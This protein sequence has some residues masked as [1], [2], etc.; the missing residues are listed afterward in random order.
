VKGISPEHGKKKAYFGHNNTLDESARFLHGTVYG[1]GSVVVDNRLLAEDRR[2]L[3]L[4][5]LDPI[6]V[7]GTGE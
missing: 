5:K 1:I 3:E 7:S 2:G 4:A 6:T